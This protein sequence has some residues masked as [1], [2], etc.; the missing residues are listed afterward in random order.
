MTIRDVVD[1]IN[2]H[3]DPVLTDEMNALVMETCERTHRLTM[4]LN[5]AYHTPDQVRAMMSEITGEPVDD[6]FTLFPPFYSDFGRNLHFGKRVFVNAGCHFQDQGG[7][8]IGDGALIGHNVVFATVDHD[9]DPT[10]RRNHYA[11]IRLGNNVW[12]GANVVFC[13][14]VTVGAYAVADALFGETPIAGRTPFQIPATMDQVLAQ[15]EDLPK[16]IVDPL[17]DYGFG[18]DVASF[19]N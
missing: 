6:S 7:V 16:D 1:Y 9:L 10:S 17:F 4:S 5:T 8:F 18:I 12:I 11:P 2:A 3:A 13:P 15:R 14:G 19:G